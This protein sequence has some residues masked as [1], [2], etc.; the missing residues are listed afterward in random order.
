MAHVA[1]PWT[2]AVA[3][4]RN[5]LL[6][7]KAVCRPAPAPRMDATGRQWPVLMKIIRYPPPGVRLKGVPTITIGQSTSE[8]RDSGSCMFSTWISS[9][10]TVFS[11]RFCSGPDWRGFCPWRRWRCRWSTTLPGPVAG[12]KW[13][14]TRNCCRW[15]QQLLG[16]RTKI[17]GS[18]WNIELQALL[19]PIS[20]GHNHWKIWRARRFLE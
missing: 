16:A 15:P 1:V 4:S 19:N 2:V 12:W 3:A 17:C 5:A 18:A 11:R 8:M 10:F 13:R 14:S 9:T 6:R 7:K 20:V